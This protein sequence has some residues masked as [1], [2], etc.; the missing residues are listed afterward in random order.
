MAVIETKF[1]V[2]DQVYDLLRKRRTTVNGVRVEK[3]KMLDG[4]HSQTLYTV[5][6]SLERSYRTEHELMKLERQYDPESKD[7]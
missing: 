4:F 1:S 3:V 5:D 7:T 2:G 6:N